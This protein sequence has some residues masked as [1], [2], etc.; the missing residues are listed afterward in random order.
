MKKILI[1]FGFFALSCN[2]SDNG[3]NGKLLIYCRESKQVLKMGNMER[4]VYTTTMPD[5]HDF[6]IIT[7]FSDGSGD[8]T[9]YHNPECQKCVNYNHG[10]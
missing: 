4:N 9:M 7:Q 8:I 2:N 10:K 6:T 5:G 3:N 1:V